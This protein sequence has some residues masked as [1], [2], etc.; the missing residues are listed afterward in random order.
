[1]TPII[2]S[3][4]TGNAFK[5]ASVAAANTKD[6]IG[7]YNISYITDEVIEKFDTFVLVYWCNRGTADNETISL[8]KRMKNKKIVIMG[9][10]GASMESDHAKKVLQNVENLVKEENTLLGN[11]LCR[12][13][14]D[15]NRTKRKL[16]IPEGMPGHMTLEKFAKQQES[17]NHPDDNDLAN[18][19]KFIEEVFNVN[20]CKK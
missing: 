16:L 4:I 11:F 14:I 19:K 10:L 5:L 20:G 7:P 8:I 18:A 13:A 3:T 12:G 1:M 6:A 17:Q 15:L 9:T 2:F